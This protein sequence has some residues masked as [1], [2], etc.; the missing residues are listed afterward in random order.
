MN[1]YVA[2]ETMQAYIQENFHQYLIAAELPDF[3]DDDVIVS[4]TDP[5]SYINPVVLFVNGD[6]TNY[7]VGNISNSSDENDM[8]I[9]IFIQLSK[10][11]KEV[12][13]R[14]AYEYI[15]LLRRCI[16]HCKEFGMVSAEESEVYSE[17]NRNDLSGNVYGRYM[18]HVRYSE[19][20]YD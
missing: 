20:K 11:T 2:L 14:R 3:L 4:S 15:S 16:N 6:I 17:W 13:I 10:D 1:G 19:D 8:K 7:N 9:N 18:V 12:L 5:L